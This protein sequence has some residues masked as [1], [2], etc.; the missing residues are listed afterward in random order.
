MTATVHKTR[1]TSIIEKKEEKVEGVAILNSKGFS[2]GL[3][4]MKNLKSF[5]LHKDKRISSC[6]DRLHREP[7]AHR[8]YTP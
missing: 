1:R 2:I 6:P 4:L 5:F 8:S 7:T 3:G